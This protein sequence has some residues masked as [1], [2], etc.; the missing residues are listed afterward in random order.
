M[1]SKT[2][3]SQ[4]LWLNTVR[5]FAATPKIHSRIPVE[6]EYYSILGIPPTATPEQIKEAYRTMV[7][8]H[9]PDVQGTAQPDA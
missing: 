8:L 6:K 2:L 7:K 4:R 3:N 5:N 1:I 9:H